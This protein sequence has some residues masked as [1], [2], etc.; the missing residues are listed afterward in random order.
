MPILLNS[1][2][3]FLFV[4]HSLVI[5]AFYMR[6]RS[7]ARRDRGERRCGRYVAAGKH[8]PG[9]QVRASRDLEG[10]PRE[11]FG[12]GEGKGPRGGQGGGPE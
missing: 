3:P 9:V 6:L 11:G 4:A 5:P 12:E 1:F 10:V 8:I 2:A 7:M